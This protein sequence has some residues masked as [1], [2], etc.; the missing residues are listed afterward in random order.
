M[1][2]NLIKTFFTSESVTEGHPDK[3][4]DQISD[5]VLDDVLKQDK[6][7]RVACEAF[8]SVGLVIVGGE[9][10]TIAWVDIQKLVR[11]LLFDIGYTETQYGLSADNCA[12]LNVIGRQSP[13]IA[14]GVDVGGAGDQGLMIGYACNE[15]KELMPLPIILAHKLCRR[16]AFVRKNKILDYLGPDGKSQVTVQYENGKPVRIS[17]IVIAAQHTEQILD[18]TGNRI[19]NKARQEI[20]ETVV[21]RVIPN[22]L[23]DRTTKYYVN[24][25]GKFVVGGP[26]S[27]T[28]M[29]G[30]K[31][32]VDTYGGLV[33]HG[34]GAF[35]G[36]DPTKVDRTASY[37][38]RYVAKN[39]VAAGICDKM[40]I[41]LAYV[42]GRPEPTHISINT[43]G[44]GKISDEKL[45]E[46]VKDLFDFTPAAMIK[47][48]DLRRPIYLPTA[49]YGHF[50][51]EEK[52][53]TWEKLDSV[54]IIKK[55]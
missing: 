35:S 29:T 47:K 44:T 2:N 39:C 32:I 7:G 49:S 17:S 51:R 10:T 40:E 1:K 55:Q 42:I 9:I 26:Q 53:F 41:S 24:E 21:K 19:T 52:N 3:L 33:R 46:V 5:A 37:Y 43:F 45:E 50:G 12:V 13:D 14:Q 15:T 8:V 54:G 22:H 31:L 25:T 11:K 6:Y 20:I 28:G 4:C 18:K 30:R 34:G 16:L 27:D 36:K 38:A 23:L 48:L